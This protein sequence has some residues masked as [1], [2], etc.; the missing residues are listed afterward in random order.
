MAQMVL[1]ITVGLRWW[2]RPSLAILMQMAGLAAR[3]GDQEMFNYFAR[4]IESIAVA[5]VY[6]VTE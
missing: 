5:G 4:F 1:E 6:A 2:L 3:V